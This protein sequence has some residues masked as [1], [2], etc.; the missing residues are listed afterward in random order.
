M[1]SRSRYALAGAA[2]L[3]MVIV[4]ACGLGSNPGAPVLPSPSATASVV[5]TP[6]PTASPSASPSATVPTPSQSSTTVVSARVAYQWRWP[7]AE[8]GG[9]AKVTHTYAVP[10]VPTLIAIGAAGHTDLG[11]PAFDR[12]GFR[13][14]TGFPAYEFKWVAKADF[15]GDASDQ[16]VAIAGDDVLKITFRQAQAHNN[17]GQSTAPRTGSVHGL[18]AVV[19]YANAGDFE[20]VVTYGLGAHRWVQQSNPQTR[21]RVYEVETVVG[22]QHIYTVAFDID[23]TH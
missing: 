22:G 23:A 5:P 18:G 8:A 12:V 3:I 7:N 10:P 21:V 17:A 4:A 15:R 14:T 9:T 19:A 11:K 6:S 20:G 13:F 2:A 1:N 16:V